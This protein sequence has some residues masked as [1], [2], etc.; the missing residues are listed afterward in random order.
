MSTKDTK[1]QV[2]NY[3]KSRLNEGTS[4][5][6]REIMDAMD[7]LSTSTAH[8]YIEMLVS[9]GL[10]EKTDNLNRTLRLPN[11]STASVPVLGTVTAG[12]PITA[13][14]YIS[15]YIGFEAEGVD[16]AELFALRIRGESMINAGILDGD[17]V[18]VRRTDYA[19]NG[20]IVVAF[21]DGEEA[22]VKRFYKR[23][24]DGISV[25]N[26]RLSAGERY[27]QYLKAKNGETKIVIGP[28]SAVFTPFDNLGLI[29]IDEEHEGSYK[30][31][32]SPKYS[33]REVAF[34]R[35]EKEGAAVILGSATPSLESYFDAQEGRIKLYELKSRAGGAELPKVHVVDLK[36]ELKARNRSI[37]SR[38]LRELI[39]DRLNRHEQ[40]MLFIN[41]R[42][43]SGF[44]NCRA[45]GNVIK[46]PHCDVSLTYHVPG[47]LVC[48][49]CGYETGMVS[50]CPKCAS[51]Y[52]S[53][54]GTGTQ[55]IE[56]LINKEYPQAKTLRMDYD[57]TR[58]KESY[59]DI[60]SAFA[61]HEADIL[62][63]TQMIVKGHDFHD[64]TLVGIILADMSLYQEDFRCAEKTFQLLSQAAGRAGRGQKAGEVVIQTYNPEHYAIESSALQDYGRFYD[65]EIDFRRLM[66]YPPVW[67]MLKIMLS[68]EDEE[69]LLRE[70]D[71]VDDFLKRELE[72]LKVQVKLFGPSKARIYRVNDVYRMVFYLKWNDYSLLS[73][74]K[75]KLSDAGTASKEV[76]MQ[77]DFNPL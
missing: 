62:I 6:V 72:R 8:R 27:D 57:T 29:I 67:T 21:I 63:G 1:I 73:K 77:F 12:Q 5:S 22:T 3:I 20:D 10:L 19:E 14:E 53:T 59:D 4:P 50:N 52:V 49:Y 69:E 60:L 44:V 34:F 25:I 38:K 28:R 54:F 17:I 46:C 70:T 39:E 31:E 35:A 42:G 11:S 7:F 43:H 45:C 37:F 13:V 71:R 41:R 16:P 30:S 56:E 36:E 18:I 32:N 51:P 40:I 9:D 33:T 15:G 61:N 26:S 74:L 23:F 76:S 64:V 65:E 66:K 48:H 47:K 2:F 58:A 55:K 68:S 24:G 75:D